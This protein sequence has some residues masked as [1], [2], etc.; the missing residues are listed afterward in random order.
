MNAGKT[1]DT[2]SGVPHELWGNLRVSMATPFAFNPHGCSP[3]TRT[4]QDVKPNQQPGELPVCRAGT[5]RHR[6]LRVPPRTQAAAGPPGCRQHGCHFVQEKKKPVSVQRA[7][8]FPSKGANNA[9]NRHIHTS[10][11]NRLRTAGSGERA[12]PAQ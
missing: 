5:R 10:L 2:A 3:V 6:R 7:A 8:G 9:N 4:R 1:G 11:S 12:R